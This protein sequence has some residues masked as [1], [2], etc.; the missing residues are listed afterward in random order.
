MSSNQMTLEEYKKYLE[1]DT[2]K[3]LLVEGTSDRIIFLRFFEE[4]LG[5]EW[6]DNSGLAIDTS[7]ILSSSSNNAQGNR[8]KV[9]LAV[10]ML[11]NLLPLNKLTGFVDRE[12]RG[13]DWESEFQD[14]LKIHVI[15]DRI[16]WTRGHSIENYF[17]N[18]NVLQIPFTIASGE[19][20][21]K[22]YDLF[23]K[24]LLYFLKTACILTL[25]ALSLNYSFDRI[26]ASI[27]WDILESDGTINTEIWSDRLNDKANFNREEISQLIKQ[28]NKYA[29]NLISINDEIL[30]WF[31]HGHISFHLIWCAFARCV[32][33]TVDNPSERKSKAQKVLEASS[34]MRLGMCA[35]YWAKCARQG[36]VPHPSEIFNLIGIALD[37]KPAH[38]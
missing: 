36:I 29:D 11:M 2:Q 1:W 31:P 12:F 24:N 35:L 34:D 5:P 20:F 21:K 26:K 7:E 23:K 9:E 38:T 13:F 33:E 30:E 15:K 22:A 14:K 6:Q 8:E 37:S 10:N 28:Y 4:F 18:I 17:L 27:G 3:H 16:V 25:S 19:T 32:Y